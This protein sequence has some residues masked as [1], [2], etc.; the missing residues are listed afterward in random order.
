LPIV[1][2][3]GCRYAGTPIVEQHENACL[4]IEA[5][6]RDETTHTPIESG[7]MMSDA[8]V[9]DDARNALIRFLASQQHE[10]PQHSSSL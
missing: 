5:Q 4:G 7:M 2:S 9:E 3:E 8:A 6:Q 10:F 1:T